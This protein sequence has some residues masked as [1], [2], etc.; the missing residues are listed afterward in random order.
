MSTRPF[1][2][3]VGASTR[4]HWVRSRNPDPYGRKTP[5]KN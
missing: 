5:K 2:A 1:C 3:Q 4:K